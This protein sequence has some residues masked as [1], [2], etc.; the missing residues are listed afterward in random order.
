MVNELRRTRG[1]L[2][3]VEGSDHNQRN[4]FKRAVVL[5]KKFHNKGTDGEF[6]DE[7]TYDTP[8][9]FNIKEVFQYIKII[10]S[11]KKQTVL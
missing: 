8:V 1:L 9:Y 11:Q 2:L 7:I 3:D 5:N 10:I 4:I 6:K